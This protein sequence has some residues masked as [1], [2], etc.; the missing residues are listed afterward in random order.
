[1]A[2]VRAIDGDPWHGSS[3]GVLLRDVTA[4][5]AQAT[6]VAGAHAIWA[7]VLHLT[8]WSDEVA[9]RLDGAP[10]AEPRARDWPPVPSRAD[11]DAWAAACG[12]L[13]AANAA[14]IA[15]L[16]RCPDDRLVAQV[17]EGRDPALGSGVTHAAMVAGLA[18]HHA[19]HGGQIALLRRAMAAG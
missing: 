11:A 8:A 3:I 12:A 6:P 9:R 17:G 19:Y 5:E 4:D 15:A 2:L 1:D 18:Q 16:D 10:P 14:A 13:R 7:L